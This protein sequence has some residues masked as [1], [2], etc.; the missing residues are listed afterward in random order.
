MSAVRGDLSQSS[1]SAA[2]ILTDADFKFIREFVYE[3]CG[4]ALSEQKRQLVQGRLARR[5][6]ELGLADFAAYC[7]L[8]RESPANELDAL[9]S[10]IS[11]NVTAFFRESHHFDFLAEEYL[12]P[13]LK[14]NQRIRIWSAGC[15]SGEEPYTIAM[16]LAEAMEK[17]NKHA[18]ALILATD[19]SPNALSAARSGTYRL[20]RI[21]GISEERRRRW[22]LR[23]SGQ[24]D[25]M[26]SV[27]PRLRELVRIQ[28][29]N[30]LHE[31]PMKGPFDCIFCRN[32]VIYFDKPTKERLFSRY[33]GM[34]RDGGYLFL[35][36]SE[37]M[38]GLSND[39]KLVGRTIYRKGS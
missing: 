14:A 26:V 2:P 1:A 29:L 7:K 11:T 13:L 28:P 3:Y 12:P 25:G 23:G 27:H 20:D 5:L 32:V 19:L 30:L 21:E 6:R 10:A 38:F 36:H 37:S 24:N 22:L 34:L 35:G 39:F 16:V 15:S 33:A 4:I 17:H 18:D 31:W 8:L 9:S